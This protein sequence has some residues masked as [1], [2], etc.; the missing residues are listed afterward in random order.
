MAELNKVLQEDDVKFAQQEEEA[1]CGGVGIS[2]V[3]RLLA[4][5]PAREKLT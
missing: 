2:A 4:G 1:V 3:A 5:N